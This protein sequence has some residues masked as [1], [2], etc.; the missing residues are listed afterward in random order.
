[1][2]K[3]SSKNNKHYIDQLEAKT[4]LHTM[5]ETLQEHYWLAKNF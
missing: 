3:F 2:R 1:M 4:V 5:E